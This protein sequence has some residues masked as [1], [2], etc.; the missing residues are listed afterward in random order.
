MEISPKFDSLKTKIQSLGALRAE[1]WELIVALAQQTKVEINQSFIR[2]EGCLAYV[3]EGLLKEYDSQ[4]RTSPAIVNFI[5]DRQCILTRKHNQHHYLKAITPT[6]VYAWG[7]EDLIQLYHHFNELKPIY[8]TLCAEYELN[9]AYRILI[10]ETNASQERIY[11]F[12][13]KFR[14]QLN[15]LKKKDIANYLQLNYTHF[16]HINSHI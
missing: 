14:A 5:S 6:L 3:A 1:A 9:V 4:N 15:F 8:N 10:L 2:K 7:F 16:L 13:E 11:L 12:R